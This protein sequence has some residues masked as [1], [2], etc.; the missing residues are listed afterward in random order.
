MTGE[1]ELYDSYI[2][3][4]GWG[5]GAEDDYAEF[6][7]W[8]TP[9]VRSGAQVLELGFGNGQFLR[10]A[11]QRAASV[12][13][14]EII[15]PLVNA[16]RSQGFTAESSTEPLS[17]PYDVIAAFDVFEHLGVDQLSQM[18]RECSRLLAPEGAIIAKFP[19]GASPFSSYYQASDATHLKPLAPRA[20]GQIAFPAGLEVVKAFNPRVVYP[21]IK[22][23]L[24]SLVA[25]TVR[26]VVERM[27]NFAYFGRRFPMDPNVVVILRKIV[28]RSGSDD[29]PRACGEIART[30]THDRAVKDLNDLADEYEPQAAMA[31]TR[32]NPEAG[33]KDNIKPL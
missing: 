6:E 24:K 12:H 21:G 19:N 31:H 30:I 7:A 29:M 28:R 16:A 26:D 9:W 1:A 13:G 18:M 11:R 2:E 23:R 4:K 5:R 22:N 32:A 15:P 20:L 3:L 14:V 33:N 27:I 10:W 25:F 17:G 8:M